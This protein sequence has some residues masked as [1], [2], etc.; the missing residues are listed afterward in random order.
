MG[1]SSL[2]WPGNSPLED[3]WPLITAKMHKK[4]PTTMFELRQTIEE[5]CFKVVTTE[6]LS[7]LYESNPKSVKSVLNAKGGTTN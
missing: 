4:K 3:V 7:T 6:Y 5:V 1:I 2:V